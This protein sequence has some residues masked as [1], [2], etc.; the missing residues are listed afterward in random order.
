[1]EREEDL[2]EEVARLWGYERIPETMPLA[3][4]GVGRLPEELTR[5]RQVR[6][7]LLRGG[8]TEVFTLSLLHPRDLD[9]VRIP[10]DHPLRRAPKLLNPLTEEHT[11]LRTTLL[12]SLLE[13][14]RT[15]RTRG[16]PDVHIFE[17]GRVYFPSGEGWEER[18]VVGIARM[19]R[20][21]LGRWNLPEDFWETTFYHLK[22]VVET[23]L[24]ELHI[25]DWRLVPEAAPWLH[26]YRAASVWIGGERIGW[27]GEVHP[28]V[29]EAYDLRGRAYVAEVALASLLTHARPP[30]FRPLPR[31]PAVDRDL[32]V[33]VREEVTAAE[34]VEEIRRVGGPVLEAVEAFDVYT[35]PQ[36]PEGHKSIAFSLRFRSPDRTL[37]AREVEGILEEIRQGLRQRFGARIRGA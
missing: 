3:E 7:I 8:L 1:V 12:P 34:L 16:I 37:E 26:P 27:M 25:P 17:I 20:M 21:L 11:H 18:K 36:V 31:Y 23:L 28:E 32:A 14:L 5:E 19:G 30:E 29:A 35:G 10:P 4:M 13:V 24:E 15:N 33:V 9:R 2:I 22:G 6:E